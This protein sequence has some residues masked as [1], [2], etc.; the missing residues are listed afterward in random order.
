MKARLILIAGPY[1]G[2]TGGDPARIADNLR[3]LEGAALAV[4]ERG[5]LPVVGEWVSLPLARAAGS[6]QIGDD[7]SERFLYPAARRLIERCDAVLRIPGE[8]KGADGDV[9]LART[10]GIPVYLDIDD[11]PE[12]V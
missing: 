11:L 3:R 5:H 9:D 6:A 4:Y 12:V 7:I 8:S 2:G 1:R 10:L